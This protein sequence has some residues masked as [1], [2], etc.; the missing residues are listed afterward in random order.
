[1][2]DIKIASDIIRRTFVP[3]AIENTNVGVLGL[4]I[5]TQQIIIEHKAFQ[6]ILVR[7][8]CYTFVCGLTIHDILIVLYL[9]MTSATEPPVLYEAST[10]LIRP[11]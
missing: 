9:L 10:L 1:M 11:N 3:C 5:P 2:L 8:R 6:L 7:Y 4:I